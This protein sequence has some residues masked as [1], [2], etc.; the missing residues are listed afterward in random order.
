MISSITWVTGIAAPPSV[1]GQITPAPARAPFSLRLVSF[2]ES[3][4]PDIEHVVVSANAA[5]AV[6]MLAEGDTA[7][8]LAFAHTPEREQ[9]AYFSD[10]LLI[11][12]PEVV[13]RRDHLHVLPRNAAGD[14]EL[15][16]LFADKSLRGA[17]VSGRSFGSYVDDQLERAPA[18]GGLTRSPASDFG[19]NT[20]AMVALGRIDYS[21]VR[22]LN[23]ELEDSHL[24]VATDALTSVPIEG[25]SAAGYAGVACP[26][27]PWGRA[28]IQRVGALLFTPEGIALLREETEHRMSAADRQRNAAQID[29][30]YRGRAR[31]SGR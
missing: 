27:T 1:P 9:L 30:L 24:G 20:L 13:V 5:R 7:C 28:V 19:S 12:P 2:L 23:M 16:R 26:R 21:L 17:V 8:V 22:E 31:A 4:W 3:H 6:K 15:P 11:T 25:A 18:T 10:A 29:A 14:V